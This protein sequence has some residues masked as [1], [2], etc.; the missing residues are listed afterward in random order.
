MQIFCLTLTEEHN[1]N[2]CALQTPFL[3][4]KEKR[5]SARMKTSP[6]HC[7]TI[8]VIYF[9]FFLGRKLL[10]CPHFFLRQLVARGCKRA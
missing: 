9:N 8:P 2:E 5:K 10:V 4:T 7:Q 3:H 1:I 6:L